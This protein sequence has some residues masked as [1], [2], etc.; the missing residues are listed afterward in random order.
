MR[1]PIEEREVIISWRTTDDTV[2]IYTSDYSYMTKFDKLVEK[3]PEAWRLKRQE[4]HKGDIVGKSYE[5]SVKCLTFR[6]EP[7]KGRE[8]TEEEKRIAAERMRKAILVR[9]HDTAIEN[10]R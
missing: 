7:P 9:K 5:T 3:H 6:S 4:L 10:Q 2:S 8:M 1:T